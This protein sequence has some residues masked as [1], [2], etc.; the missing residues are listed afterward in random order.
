MQRQEVT[1][2]Q[3]FWTIYFGKIPGIQNIFPDTN[4]G[5]W[6]RQY[7]YLKE[8]PCHLVMWHKKVNFLK[9]YIFLFLTFFG[10]SKCIMW[11]V[12]Y[13][14]KRCNFSVHHLLN[15]NSNVHIASFSGIN[16]F[17]TSITIEISSTCLLDYLKW[18]LV[19]LKVGYCVQS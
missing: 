19:G 15:F 14:F 18:H 6:I 7:Q 11:Y 4:T 16:T 9:T 12:L 13:Q 17:I 5:T 3:S 1:V 10:S 2:L 8:L